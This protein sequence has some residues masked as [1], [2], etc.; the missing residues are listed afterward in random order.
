VDGKIDATRL[1]AFTGE[2]ELLTP[3]ARS[4]K[5]IPGFRPHDM[6]QPTVAEDAPFV[7]SSTRPPAQPVFVALL[8]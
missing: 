4:S 1:E 5:A 3:P 2:G 7:S 8:A 6:A